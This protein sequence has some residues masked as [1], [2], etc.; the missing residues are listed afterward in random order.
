MNVSQ[1]QAYESYFGPPS[2]F[3]NVTEFMSSAASSSA[4]HSP[5]NPKPPQLP[6]SSGDGE[7]EWMKSWHGKHKEVEMECRYVVDFYVPP[8]VLVSDLEW[9]S[10]LVSRT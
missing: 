2:D 9:M 3:V 10:F 8:P 6:G 5:M 4:S 1:G 7:A